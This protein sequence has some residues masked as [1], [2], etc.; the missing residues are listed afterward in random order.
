ML[1]GSS[2]MLHLQ[3]PVSCTHTGDD[4]ACSMLRST[5]HAAASVLNADYSIFKLKLMLKHPGLLLQQLSGP[6][7]SDVL[8]LI[9]IFH[10]NLCLDQP[11]CARHMLYL[12]LYLYR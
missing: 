5:G 3:I 2:I 11:T 1:A 8:Y 10:V 4:V 7:P 12:P 6:R 9:L